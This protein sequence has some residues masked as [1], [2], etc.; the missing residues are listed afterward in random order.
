MVSTEGRKQAMETVQSFKPG[1]AAPLVAWGIGLAIV[2]PALAAAGLEM[3]SRPGSGGGAVILVMLAA[4]VGGLLA[5]G[6]LIG[7]CWRAAHNSDYVAAVTLLRV[8]HEREA[9][10]VKTG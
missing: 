10:K 8:A 9:Q 3:G 2:A 5:A 4:I 6:L 7:G 1:R